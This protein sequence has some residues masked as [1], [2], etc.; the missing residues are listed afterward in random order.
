MELKRGEGM[1]M[2]VAP[3]V[4]RAR[5]MASMAKFTGVVSW[6]GVRLKKPSMRPR[7]IPRREL[8]PAM[9]CA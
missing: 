1:G 9:A 4:V 2:M 7:R 6:L 5:V 3:A 8:A